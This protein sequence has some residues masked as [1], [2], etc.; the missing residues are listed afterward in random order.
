MLIRVWRHICWIPSPGPTNNPLH[1]SACYPPPHLFP[2]HSTV[3]CTVVTLKEERRER[4]FPV[5]LF[6][7][8]LEQNERIALFHFS[9]T[10]AKK[11]FAL[12]CQKTSN[13]QEKPKS[14][15]PT[16]CFTNP[17]PLPV[18]LPSVPVP[19]HLSYC[20]HVPMS[21][22]NF[23]RFSSAQRLFRIFMRVALK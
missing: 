9:T 5:A 8:R 6:E 4:F 23:F 14:E 18:L 1:I 19:P 22:F 15:F 21:L 7:E 17:V 10:R 11:Q 16:L 13:S 2:S 20:M 3:Q 12:F